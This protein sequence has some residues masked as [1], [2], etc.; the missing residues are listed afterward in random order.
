MNDIKIEVGAFSERDKSV[1]CAA[2]LYA[3]PRTEEALTLH[4]FYCQGGSTL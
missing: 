3:G 4:F 1:Y 2:K